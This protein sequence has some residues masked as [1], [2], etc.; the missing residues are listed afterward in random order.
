MVSTRDAYGKTLAELG[1]EHEDIVALDCDLS[2]STRSALFGKKFPRRF[3]NMGVSEQDMIGT[4]AGLAATGKVPFASTFAVFASGRAWEQI[5]VCVCLAKLNVKVVASHGGI[6][7]GEDGATHQATEDLAIM[8]AL[9][10]MS[11]VVPADGVETEQA[12]RAIYAHDGPV[13]LRLARNKYPILFDES[14]RFQLGK[15]NRVREGKDLAI[16]AVGLMVSKSLLAAEQLARQGVE[17]SVVNMSTI[18]PLDAEHVVGAARETGAVLTVE[19]HSING[20]LG[21]AVAET[22]GENFP[23]PMKRMGVNDRFGTSG[24]S[25]ELLEY[26]GLTERHIAEEALKLLKMKA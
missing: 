21:S 17:A 11:V 18:K 24:S 10:N 19:E 7:V 12:V 8:R 1:D 25:D 2:G 22:L 14:Y 23:V 6:T 20:G 13:Y 15:A 4:A 5:R 16:I 3:F 9:P 26:H